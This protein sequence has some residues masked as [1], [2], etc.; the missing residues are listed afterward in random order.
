[1]VPN[2][3]WI[4]HT[5]LYI[6]SVLR[7]FFQF[8][9]TQMTHMNLIFSIDLTQESGCPSFRALF[10]RDL[11]NK[12]ERSHSNEN[13]NSYFPC[14]NSDQ[15]TIISY[16][17]IYHI[18]YQYTCYR[19]YIIFLLKAKLIKKTFF[20]FRIGY[21]FILAC[22]C[23][24]SWKHVWLTKYFSHCERYKSN[25]PSCC[26]STY[27]HL[28]SFP[29]CCTCVALWISSHFLQCCPSRG[30]A[31]VLQS[32]VVPQFINLILPMSLVSN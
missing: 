18:S 24:L 21:S 25:L 11:K 29:P 12:W 13:H 27:R 14:I 32:T 19:D 2:L 20:L 16:H 10:D 5:F 17:I 28:S 6:T 30:V 23:C 26:L 31:N 9:I 15:Y 7:I 1:M 3:S 22:I 8:T 4:C